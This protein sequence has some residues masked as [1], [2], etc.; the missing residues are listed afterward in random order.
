MVCNIGSCRPIDSNV[1][2]SGNSVDM[3]RLYQEAN[4][5]L[6]VNTGSLLNNAPG[7]IRTRD[8]RFRRPLLYPTELPGLRWI[9]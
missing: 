3:G 9:V 1:G 4:I 6:Y 5:A 7:T 8:L 2:S